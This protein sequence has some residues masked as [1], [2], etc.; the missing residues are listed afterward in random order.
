MAS[1]RDKFA[2]R[3]ATSDDHA[4]CARILTQAWV[5]ALP[6]RRRK[7]GLAEF[8][9][10]TE[11]ELLFV[12]ACKRSVVGFISIWEQE[13]FVHHLFVDPAFQ[14]RGV[15]TRL[16]IH[17]STLAG[18]RE[19]SLKCPTDNQSAIRFYTRL[20]FNPTAL[21]GVDEFGEWVELRG[22]PRSCSV[23]PTTVAAPSD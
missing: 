15:G 5:S 3:E 17:V 18:D 8:R 20:G 21:Q 4:I 7:V 16:L 2:V 14:N 23:V 22:R 9:E 11:G 10:Q 19:L 6:T 12:A 13:W 1:T